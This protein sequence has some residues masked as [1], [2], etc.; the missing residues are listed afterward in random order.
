MALN[1]ALR[2]RPGAHFNREIVADRIPGLPIFFCN[3]ARWKPRGASR[4]NN[5][6]STN[7]L[8]PRI[9]RWTTRQLLLNRP[10]PSERLTQSNEDGILPIRQPVAVVHPDDPGP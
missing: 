3:L 2:I 10:D 9:L 5:S 7:P 4:S 6:L 1:K 8:R